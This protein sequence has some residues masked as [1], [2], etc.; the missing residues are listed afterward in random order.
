[1]IGKI[2]I[3]VPHVNYDINKLYCLNSNGKKM[4]MKFNTLVFNATMIIIE[5]LTT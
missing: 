5:N 3:I 1:M 2:M 4:K